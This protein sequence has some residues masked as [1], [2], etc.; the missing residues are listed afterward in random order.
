MKSETEKKIYIPGFVGPHVIIDAAA[1]KEAVVL[2]DQHGQ[3]LAPLKV[4]PPAPN[5]E[6]R[7]RSCLTPLITS[8]RS[9]IEE[10]RLPPIQVA[11]KARIERMAALRASFTDRHPAT[12][13]I[14]TQLLR[15]SDR[16]D[17]WRKVHTELDERVPDWE[18]V[19]VSPSF[20]AWLKAVNPFT[21]V[22]RG[23]LFQSLDSFASRYER[24]ILIFFLLRFL[25]E[26]VSGVK[27]YR[28]FVEGTSFQRGELILGR[29]EVLDKLGAGGV[30]N[31]VL[32]YSHEV[33]RLYALK[34]L[35]HEHR[36]NAAAVAR[37]R[38]EAELWVAIGEH[39]NLVSAEII[40][41]TAGELL[42]FME[43]V[44]SDSR[45]RATLADHL[46]GPI[47]LQQAIR[48]ALQ[49][50]DG[51]THAYGRGMRAHRDIKPANIL[52]DRD[53]SA[54]ITDLGLAG[55]HLQ[56][57]KPSGAVPTTQ[58]AFETV[59]GS[60]FGTPPYMSPEQ[61]LD[62]TACDQQSDIY[63]FGVVLFQLATAGTLPF[64]PSRDD[65]SGIFAQFA[66]L[67]MRQ[68][69]PMVASPL[70]GV[71]QGC[72]RK[73]RVE[74]F[75]TFAEVRQALCRVAAAVGIDVPA[76]AMQAP[77][78]RSWD[79]G[80]RAV[81]LE[82]LG[83]H[84]E[85][86]EVYREF[87]STPLAGTGAQFDLGVAL[88]RNRKYAEAYEAFVKAMEHSPAAT[89]ALRAE[90]MM[91]LNRPKEALRDAECALQLEHD[92]PKA[93]HA[94]GW[95]LQSA[96]RFKESVEAL[97]HALPHESGNG[98]FWLRFAVSNLRL[99]NHIDAKEFAKRAIERLA[100]SERDARNEA[101]RIIDAPVPWRS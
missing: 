6:V 58:R 64:M 46:S 44:E 45:G 12:N 84:D 4:K 32:V 99:H 48:W 68:P 100:P 19:V 86:L 56:E 28:Q 67:H 36:A 98:R 73:R 66:R 21:Q 34:V 95:A 25:Q 23:N 97:R 50:C 18:R 16:T 90:C 30:G 61:F 38:K 29:Y 83:K 27:P 26:Q 43:Y 35:R 81:N 69:V 94:K 82:R 79:V 54:R 76:D 10:K 53:G 39:P 37:F 7:Y 62:A 3:R 60:T 72:L 1:P 74:R 71:V 51:M 20:L 78:V 17:K 92:L 47:D 13:W 49:C 63:S 93:W 22:P 101:Q 80:Q 89:Y 91:E 75:F 9:A 2:L 57:P 85:A 88:M 15:C 14:P 65:G 55:M 8:D 87:A 5:N 41:S 11:Q 24:P 40:E 70:N 59:V 52:V 42:I 96:A 31:V 33:S 77:E